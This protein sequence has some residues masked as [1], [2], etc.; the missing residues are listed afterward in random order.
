MSALPPDE[1]FATRPAPAPGGG[2]SP[3]PR[4][5]SF[6]QRV[7]TLVGLGEPRA[8]TLVVVL[9]I[10]MIAA[11]PVGGLTIL[12]VLTVLSGFSFG[13]FT[14][15]AA[16]ALLPV[17]FLVLWFVWLD[18]FDPPRWEYLAIAFAW[19]AFA[20]TYISLKVNMAGEN[21]FKALHLPESNVAVFVAPFIEESTKGLAP[22]LLLLLWLR[23]VIG[24]AYALMYAGLSAT[25]FAMTENILYLGGVY[26]SGEQLQGP[27]GAVLGVATLIVVRLGFTGFIHPLFTS[28]TGI[29]IG[30]ALRTSNK[31]LRWVF[32]IVGW[33]TAVTLHGSWNGVATLAQRNEN[34]GLIG[35]LY[36][37]ESL[38][39]LFGLVVLALWARTAP[40]RAVRQVLPEYVRSGWLSPPEVGSLTTLRR[41]LWARRW[42][43]RVAGQEGARAMR[44]YQIA[45][46]RLAL[47]RDARNH[48]L[49]DW[50]PGDPERKLTEQRKVFT[51]RDSTVPPAWWDGKRYL[52]TFPDGEKRA[53]DPPPGDVMP[54]PTAPRFPWDLPP[55]YAPA[56]PAGYGP[57]GPGHGSGGPGYGPG[58]PGYGPGGPGYGPGGPR[59]GPG[60]PGQGPG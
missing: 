50:E 29:G 39:L 38:P 22:L 16:I 30:L 37:L 35:Y 59:Y 53:V 6:G 46:T 43:K 41:R 21:V 31:V 2:A 25:G 27:L 12:F 32:P 10:I 23:E 47:L 49:R 11:L 54:L 14:A 24:V 42:A 1:T 34:P 20:A 33:L 7:R 17:P 13:L 56:P 48:G 51:G 52:V 3:G 18:R 44:S 60:G 5:D 4:S 19:G 26:V 55:R 9:R 58:G 15:S 40:G 36:F 28:M 8:R 57:G 45:C